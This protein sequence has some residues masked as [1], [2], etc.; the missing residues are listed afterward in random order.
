MEYPREFSPQARAK[1]EAAK[2]KARRQYIKRR[3]DV[4]LSRYGSDHE[5]NL[6]EYI[7]RVFLAFAEE[8]CK[9]GSDGTFGA[10]RIQ[11]ESAEFLRRFTIEAYYEDGYDRGGSRLSEMTSHWGGGLLARVEQEYRKSPDWHEYE[12]LLMVTAEKIARGKRRKAGA[13]ISGTRR[14]FIEAFI[15]KLKD[16]GHKINRKHI[17]TVAGYREATEFE[18]YQRGSARTGL[19][20]IE[21]FDRVLRMQPEDFIRALEKLRAK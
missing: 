16:H 10:D 14:A 15:T 21:N 6:R 2:L 3:A 18:R 19:N 8:A 17:W 7:L 12:R 4:A 20:A 5:R 1:V 13:T 11:V 9:L